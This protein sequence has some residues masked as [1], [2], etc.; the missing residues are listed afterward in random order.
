MLDTPES[1]EEEQK[2]SYTSEDLLLNANQRR[3]FVHLYCLKG[4]SIKECLERIPSEKRP[5]AFLSYRRYQRHASHLVK[6]HRLER[7][8]G[9]LPDTL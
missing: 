9:Q 7:G 3:M 8:S 4:Y 6:Q 2:P 5:G 1:A